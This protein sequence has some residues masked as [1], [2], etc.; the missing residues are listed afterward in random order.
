MTEHTNMLLRLHATWWAK[1]L[2]QPLVKAG[3]MDSTRDYSRLHEE[4]LE[5]SRQEYWSGLPF[6]S[7]MHEGEK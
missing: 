7:P 6:P 2:K 3:E 5:A 4:A 1:V